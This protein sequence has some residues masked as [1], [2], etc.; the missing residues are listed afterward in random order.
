V[1]SQYFSTFHL[2]IGLEP[3]R[4]TGSCPN[5]KV[6]SKTSVTC[7]FNYY[8][9]IVLV[10]LVDTGFKFGSRPSVGLKWQVKNSWGRRDYPTLFKFN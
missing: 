2:S 3:G 10:V 4:P 8:Y 6:L 9:H 1:G 5:L 7:I